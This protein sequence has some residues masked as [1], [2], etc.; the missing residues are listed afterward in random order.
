MKQ[1]IKRKDVTDSGGSPAKRAKTDNGD[2]P[3]GDTKVDAPHTQLPKGDSNGS[4]TSGEKATNG[5]LK[6]EQKSC[7]DSPSMA[8]P[9]GEAGGEESEEGELEE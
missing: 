7:K 3:E 2:S 1:G 6:D 5:T 4:K 8:G 9:K